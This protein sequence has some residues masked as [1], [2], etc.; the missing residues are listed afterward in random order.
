M[1]SPLILVVT[2]LYHAQKVQT[3]DCKRGYSDIR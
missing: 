1:S 2:T 3:N